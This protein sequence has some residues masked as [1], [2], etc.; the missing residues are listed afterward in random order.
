MLEPAQTPPHILWMDLEMTGLNPEVDE[1][2]EMASIITDANLNIIAEG[3]EIVIHLP[4]SRF[5]QMDDWNREHHTDSGL[6][7]KVL[8]STTS[9]DEAQNKTLDFLKA[10]LSPKMSPLAGSSIWQDRRFICKY[11]PKI[12]EFLHYRLIDVSSFKE[13]TSRWYPNHPTKLEKKNSHRALD[14]I[15]ESIDELKFYRQQFFK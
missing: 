7:A 5:A 3:P 8:A 2:I 4:D 13:M 15:R 9:L 14:D 6:W 11:M 1:I 10:H 12:D